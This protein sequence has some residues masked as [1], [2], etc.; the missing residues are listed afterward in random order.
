MDSVDQETANAVVEPAEE[1]YSIW[2]EPW[3][4]WEGSFELG[5]NG[6][7]GNSETFNIQFG[8]KLKRETDFSTSTFEANYVDQSSNGL[9]TAK[10][11]IAEGRV[12]FPFGESPW[13]F[14]VHVFGEY[15]EFKAFD[16]R[17]TGDAGLAYALI[18]TDPTTLKVRAGGGAS[19]EFGGVDD[20]VKPEVIFGGEWGHKF[21]DRQKMSLSADYYPNVED[22]GDARINTRASWEVVVAPK[23]GL[24]LKLSAIN[25]YD[26]TP[27]AGTRHNDL[28]YAFLVLW[29]L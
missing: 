27:G 7:Q 16:Y 20:D 11:V 3:R 13:S 9:N 21:S 23:W 18:D 6:T 14:F 19:K 25:R 10:N 29:S 15:D 17:L 5:L 12:E 22:F 1:T 24:S 8:A 4:K 2:W 28:N 26:S